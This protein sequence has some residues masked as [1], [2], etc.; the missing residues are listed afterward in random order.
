MNKAIFLDRDGTINFVEDKYYVHKKEDFILNTGVIEAM[1]M[2]QA[3]GFIFIIISN[4]SGVGKNIYTKADA[5]I[6]H[7]HMLD[8]F[9]KDGI[10]V[11]EI[12]YCT[13]HPDFNGKCICRKPD[14]LLIEKAVARF[15]IDKNKSWFIGDAE[16]DIEAANRAGIRGILIPQ[17]ENL[18]KYAHQILNTK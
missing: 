14:S 15:E 13:H 2:L 12:Y 6:L 7:E 8:L 3:D 4:Q 17:N 5:D 11:N 9:L 10:R 1:K 16:R 18:V